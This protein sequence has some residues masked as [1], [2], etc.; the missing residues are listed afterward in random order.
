METTHLQCKNQLIKDICKGYL[1]NASFNGETLPAGVILNPNNGLYWIPD[2]IFVPNISILKE[3]LINEFHNS[4]G[5]H[6][7]ERTRSVILRTF[8]WPNFRKEVK[9]FVKTCPKCERIKPRTE[10]PYG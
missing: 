3:R 4:V 9:T 10:K 1:Q 5:H 7:Y 6:D 8:H 2:K